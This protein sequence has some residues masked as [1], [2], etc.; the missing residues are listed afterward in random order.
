M[1]PELAGKLCLAFA[2]TARAADKYE[3]LHGIGDL[4]QWATKAGVLSSAESGHLAKH[5]E[6]NRRQAAAD[7]PGRLES[8][9]SCAPSSPASRMDGRCGIGTL[10]N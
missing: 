8:A 9:I 7:L 2:D 5:Y 10:P 3:E 6:G 4:L 1:Q